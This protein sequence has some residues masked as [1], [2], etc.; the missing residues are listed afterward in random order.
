MTGEWSTN[1][2]RLGQPAD[3]WQPYPAAAV[4]NSRSATVRQIWSGN[5]G[6]MQARMPPR[7][8]NPHGQTCQPPSA[9]GG[10]P[11]QGLRHQRTCPSIILYHSLNPPGQQEFLPRPNPV[12][13]PALYTV[14]PAPAGIQNPKSCL[15]CSSMFESVPQFLI[16]NSQFLIGKIR[17]IHVNSPKKRYNT[18]QSAGAKTTPH[19]SGRRPGG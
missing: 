9:T 14:L 6:R 2:S 18:P 13:A 4:A 10:A 11:G 5:S 12:L 15:S 3:K 19:P 16:P 17:S 8:G 7:A 1:G